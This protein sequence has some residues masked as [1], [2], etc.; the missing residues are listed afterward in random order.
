MKF[1][2]ILFYLLSVTL[3]TDVLAQPDVRTCAG[4]YPYLTAEMVDVYQFPQ[5]IFCNPNE[6]PLIS[7]KIV[8]A[9]AGTVTQVVC[10]PSASGC[11]P[12]VFVQW[13][14]GGTHSVKLK[15]DCGLF[16]TTTRT[17]VVS[18]TMN[19]VNH[20][21]FSLSNLNT[22]PSPGTSITLNR[23]NASSGPVLRH[24]IDAFEVNAAG[25]YNSGMY[26]SSNWIES[27]FS[28]KTIGSGINFQSGKQYR[29]KLAVQTECSTWQES[30]S[31]IITIKNCTPTVSFK[32]NDLTTNPVDLYACNN[33][34]MILNN[35]SS[36]TAG[37]TPIIQMRFTLHNSNTNC[38]LIGTLAGGPSPFPQNTAYNLRILFPNLSNTPGWYRLTVE[39]NNSYGWSPAQ[40]RCLRVNAAVSSAADFKFLGGP[41]ISGGLPI[42]RTPMTDFYGAELGQTTLGIFLNDY[43]TNISQVDWYKVE[44]WE[45]NP[46]TGAIIVNLFNSGQLPAPLPEMAPFNDPA[47]TNGYFFGLSQ[48]AVTNKRFKV[49]FTVTNECGTNFQESYFH[50]R[51]GCQFC[52]TDDATQ[53]TGLSIYPNPVAEKVFFD[54][55]SAESTTGSLQIIDLAG[56]QVAQ[57]PNIALQVGSNQLDFDCSNLPEGVYL[58]RFTDGKQQFSGKFIKTQ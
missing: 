57:L 27:D 11:N 2:F 7:V 20:S 10:Q 22:C 25:T 23:S 17:C 51:P 37:A 4:P 31:N 40:E 15:Y 42:N 29:V 19:G 26:Y 35:N 32:I 6:D 9:E 46:T 49:R 33:A 38:T 13:L 3:N 12:Q 41:T 24:W 34:P 53:L 52:K 50:L 1:Y 47:Y 30:L 36:V 5:V 45:T 21:S 39:A 28:T 16:G 18:V 44:L 54:I 55:F 48:T 56:N 8:P 14:K 43:V 58:C